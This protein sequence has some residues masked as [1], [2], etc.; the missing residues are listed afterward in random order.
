LLACFALCPRVLL[1]MLDSPP[2]QVRD[3]LVCLVLR[4]RA[5]T[6]LVILVASVVTIAGI[7][8]SSVAPESGGLT[9]HVHVHR[10]CCCTLQRHPS[11]AGMEK[12]QGSLAVRIPDKVSW[13]IPSFQKA[14]GLTTPW[15]PAKFCTSAAASAAA[16]AAQAPFKGRDG[17]HRVRG[18]HATLKWTGKHLNK[19]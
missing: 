5:L 6:C 16:V 19:G 4:S 13:S 15:P 11:K 2:P 7:S 18:D 10:C 9:A 14:E 8:V 12:N 17:T 1:R 3:S